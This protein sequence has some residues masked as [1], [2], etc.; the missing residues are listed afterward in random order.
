MSKINHCPY[1]GSVVESD[2]QFCQNCGA[3]IRDIIEPSKPALPLYAPPPRQESYGTTSVYEQPATTV[4]I[5]QKKDDS[6][7]ALSLIFGILG[8]VIFPIF[9][10]PAIIVGHISLSKSKN[11]LAIIGLVLGYLVLAVIIG[12][13]IWI[14]SVFWWY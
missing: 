11:P 1:C 12:I 2:S 14:G 3:S 4:Y 6:L 10:I 5:P 13:I 9:S 8:I 7:G